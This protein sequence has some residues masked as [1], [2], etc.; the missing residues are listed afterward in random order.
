MIDYFALALGHGLMAI[1][2]L[3]LVMRADVDADPLLEKLK[4][5]TAKH[6]MAGSAARRRARA[7]AEGD[8]H[9]KPAQQDG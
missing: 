1:A 4:N 9:G 3:Q 5:D 8:T 6:R 2:L 7:Q